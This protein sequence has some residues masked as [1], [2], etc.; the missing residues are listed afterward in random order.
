MDAVL[1]R[2]DLR[3]AREWG[4]LCAVAGHA[5]RDLADCAGRYRGLFAA[6]PFDPGLFATLAFACAYGAAWLPPDRLRVATRTCLW[7]FG[8][9][10]LVDYKARSRAE[11]RGVVDACL[12]VADGGDPAPGDDLAR[13]LADL[14]DELADRPDFAALRPIWRDEL[15]RMLEAMAREWDW[16]ADPHRP[17]PTFEEYLANADNLG[18]SFAFATHLCLTGT[19]YTALDLA[20]LRAAGRA[21]Q[22]VIRLLNDLG[23][24]ERDVSWGDLNVLLLGNT[25]A[26]V[27]AH[28]AALT[29]RCGELIGPLRARHPELTGYLSRQLGFNQGFYRISDYWG[30]R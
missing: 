11:V 15:R 29:D 6:R 20:E 28:V 24:Y 8:L 26:Q 7:C 9:D 17:S 3:E 21:V 5:Q 16:R 12:A 2:P 14:R 13:F 27:S 23:T 25:R 18:F 4:R 19:A 22:R 10:W 1:T 30:R